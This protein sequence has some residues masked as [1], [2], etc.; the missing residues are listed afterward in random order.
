MSLS[1]DQQLI[2]NYAHYYDREDG[3]LEWR[4]LG[5]LDK[6]ANIIRLCS[7]L[8]HNHTLDI[9]CGEG[10]VLERLATL[11]F[12]SQFT[13]L[14]ISES[15]VRM[16]Q[17]KNIR[18]VEARLFDGY[19]LPFQDKSFDLAILSHVIEHVE[20][21]RRLIR[22]AAR[23]AHNVFIEVPLES[24][25]RLSSDFVFDRVGHINFYDLK[26]IRRL[27]QSCGMRILDARLSH[28][29]RS[30]Y[31]YR[32]GRFRGTASYF[33]KELGLRL[34]PRCAPNILVYNYSLTYAAV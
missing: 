21:P 1:V 9:G 15:G 13:G 27:V 24:T 19:E 3:V 32:K 4:R 14:E 10:A 26:G 28:G 25:W 2:D 16:V 6:S 34:W 5:A 8:Q 33:T 17:D 29:S 12:G 30:S 7:R 31:V 22:E 11:G 18:G 23:V 20:Y